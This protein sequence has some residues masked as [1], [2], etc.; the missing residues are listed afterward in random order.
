MLLRGLRIDSVLLLLLLRTLYGR[1]LD[2]PLIRPDS[3]T[4]ILI[5]CLTAIV[6]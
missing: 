1:L 3:W 4:C 5:L 6:A 2:S